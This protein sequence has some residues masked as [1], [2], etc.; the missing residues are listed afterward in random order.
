MC[1]REL[2]SVDMHEVSRRIMEILS[3]APDA[4]DLDVEAAKI[5]NASKVD[6]VFDAQ[7]ALGLAEQ[8]AKGILMPQLLGR[9]T[10]MGLE[11]TFEPGVF[12]VREETELLGW[13]AVNRLQELESG[14]GKTP[15][16]L[17]VIDLG[18]GSGNLT[19]G[20]SK[21]VP[22]ARVWA[23]DIETACIT[24]TKKNV[25][26]HDLSDRVEVLMGDLFAPLA[27]RGLEG[28]IDAVV[29]NPPY[30]ASVRLE[31]D[32][33]YLV[34]NE[35]RAAFDGGPFGISIQM[36]LAKEAL[37]F[38]KPG[39]WLLFEFG[40]GQERQVKQL[41]ERTDGYDSVDFARNQKG[42]ARVSVNRKKRVD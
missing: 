13:T 22:N 28:S 11:L 24:L 6:G 16:E 21:A 18:T 23:I 36:R 40:V 29:C 39:G 19:C 3:S 10:F 34:A 26:R 30:I 2:S 33:A 41:I 35:P 9:T 17:R 12:A 4:P 38:L 5:I 37:P 25:E 27:G 1:N 20:I 32:R 14:S 31:K 8:R 15:R 7:R 42:E